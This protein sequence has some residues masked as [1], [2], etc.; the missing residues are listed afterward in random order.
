M[1]GG[2]GS[3]P[4]TPFLAPRG[5]CGDPQSLTEGL[6]FGAVA[7][8]RAF[9]ATPELNATGERGQGGGGGERDGDGV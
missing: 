3:G 9:A 8:R 5:G 1:L 7:S 4:L 2:V 6:C